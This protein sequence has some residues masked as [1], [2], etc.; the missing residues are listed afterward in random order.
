MEV[1]R[2]LKKNDELCDIYDFIYNIEKYIYKFK[3]AIVEDVAF[4]LNDFKK[5]YE[6]LNKKLIDD[7]L[8]ERIKKNYNEIDFLVNGNIKKVDIRRFKADIKEYK[9]LFL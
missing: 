7:E 4:K 2:I 3:C 1:V 6:N 8:E 5:E 9:R